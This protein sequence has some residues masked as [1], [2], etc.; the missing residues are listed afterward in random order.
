MLKHIAFLLVFLIAFLNNSAFS[1]EVV[2]PEVMLKNV[3][4]D[5]QVKAVESADFLILN[6]DTLVLEEAGE[7]FKMKVKLADDDIHFTDP[8]IRFEKPLVI[9]GWLSLLPPLIAIVLAL[10]F[11]EVLSSLFIGIFI[12]AATIGYYGGGISGIFAAFFTVLDHYILNALI[13]TGHISVILFSVLIGAIVAIISKNGGMQ[14]VVNRLVK[15]ATN[16]K[17]GMLTAYFLG[18]AIFFD[19]YANTLVV[20]NTM[21][22]ITDRLKIS[23]QKLAYIVD[24]TAAPIAAVAFITTWI[25]AELTYISD[26]IN[27]IQLQQGVV[28]DESAYGVF[29]NSL[30]Y[31]FYPVFSLFFVFF[32]LY[33]Q[34]DFGPMYKAEIKA[35]KEGVTADTVTNRELEE[36]EP[37]KNAKSRAY[38]AIIPVFI[39]ITGTFLGLIVTGLSTS[40]AELLGAGIDLSNGTWAAIG[41]EGSDQVGF[42]RKLGIVIGNAD[43]YLALLWSSMS[44]LAVAIIMTISQ[45]IMSL[46]EA[47]D[48]V[49]VGINTMMP[50]VVILILAWSL[51]GVTESLGTAE[52]LKAFF[53][54]DFSHVWVIPALTFVLSAFIAF[55]TGSSWST[56]ALM[57]PLVIPLSFAVAAG[58]PNFSEMAIMY[59]TIASVLAGSV[60]GDHCSPISDTT[61]LSSLATSCDHI[62]HVRTQM[63]YALTVGAVA[64]LVGVIPAAFGV[65]SLVV[66]GVGILLLYLVVHFVGKKV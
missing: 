51:A 21:R 65:P 66:F 29:M 52:Y 4:T 47:M 32:M 43:S 13:D 17:S 25:G 16:R 50:A 24:S 10:I 56:M 23:R 49:V 15:F 54:N 57:Y 45:R 63:P 6:G 14:G 34:R 22:P 2:F 42:F 11:K 46:R 20:G 5:V 31:S 35:I 28:I 38:N 3:P 26:G 58:D 55:S 19:D 40:H 61:I 12:G 7:N 44:G 37:V 18:L 8:N 9:P 62:E 59:N 36:F 27:K 30:A 48:T 39:V 60:L 41:T 53:G 33:K 64:L 1:Q